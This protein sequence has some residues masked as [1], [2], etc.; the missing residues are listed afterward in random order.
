MFLF[1]LIEIW[2]IRTCYFTYNFCDYVKHSSLLLVLFE[3][4]T[5]CYIFI[6]LCP[7]IN[8]PYDFII[9]LITPKIIPSIID[10]FHHAQLIMWQFYGTRHLV[11]GIDNYDL[12]FGDIW[13]M[14][15]LR[16]IYGSIIKNHI[17]SSL[18]CIVL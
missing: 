11:Y 1:I 18:L 2:I 4:N 8:I 6:I 13:F 17:M 3:L 12:L 9:P 5:F 15:T 16:E 7:L 10:S 14:C